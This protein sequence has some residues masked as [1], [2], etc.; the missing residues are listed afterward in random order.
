[1]SLPLY[2]SHNH[3]QA[4]PLA[5]DRTAILAELDRQGLV[6]AVANGTQE[7]DWPAVL[8]L[9]QQSPKV[10]PSFGLHPWYV[11]Q[12]STNWQATLLQHLDQIPSGIGEIGLDR[13]IENYD[14]PQQEEVFLWQWRLAAKRHLPASIHCLRAW[15]RLLELLQRESGP[16]CG[17]LLHSYGGPVEMISS[18]V[19][20][21]AYFSISGYFAHE[22]KTCQRE[23]FRHVPPDRLLIETDAPDML[24]PGK[25]I[26]F[27]LADAASGKALNHPANLRAIYQ[28]VGELLNQPIDT[29]A[30]RT[31]EN[32]H[33][34][35][36]ALV[37]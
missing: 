1:M 24:P 34:L 6:K 36:A 27:P 10:I 23:T 29:V 11:A 19:K 2:D 31:A 32:F 26:E 15:G 37:K 13:W 4:A 5:A 18:F 3:L 22:R 7:Q 21:G 30:S 9:A 17:F 16:R 20:L 14:S 25:Y 8:A 35:F 33:R 12:R 28:F